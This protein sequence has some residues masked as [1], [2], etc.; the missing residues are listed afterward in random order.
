MTGATLKGEAG[1]A[2]LDALTALAILATTIALSMSALSVARR[3]S[4][5]ASESN[6]ARTMLLLLVN[7]PLK[8]PGTYSGVVGRFDWT[9]RVTD[10]SAPASPVHLCRQAASVTGRTSDR[11]YDLERHRPCPPDRPAP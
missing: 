2:A 7:E 3:A 4:L 6:A 10:E 8:P 9:L 5:A 11:R 1:F